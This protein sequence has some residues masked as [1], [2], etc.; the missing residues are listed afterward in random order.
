M[1]DGEVVTVTI[2]PDGRMNRPTRP[3]TWDYRRKLSPCMRSVALV[4]SSSSAAGSS[5]FATTWIGG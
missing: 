3:A 4:R 5:I 1:V 2:L